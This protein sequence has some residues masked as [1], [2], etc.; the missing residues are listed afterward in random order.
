MGR[1]KKPYPLIQNSSI[2][3]LIIN[4]LPIHFGTKTN[5]MRTSIKHSITEAKR[6]T[7]GKVRWVAAKE[8]I[9]LV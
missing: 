1:G 3:Q 4:Q 2:N 5:N 7:K 8:V 9:A 6:L